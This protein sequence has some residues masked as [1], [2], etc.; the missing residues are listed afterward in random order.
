MIIDLTDIPIGISFSERD[1]NLLRSGRIQSKIL[2]M[3]DKYNFI[4]MPISIYNIIEH[5]SSFEHHHVNVTEGIFKVGSVFGYDCYVDMMILDNRIILS[6][7]VQSMRNN[8]INAILGK[9]SLL[10][11]LEIDVIL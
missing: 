4:I 1:L 11:D 5:H 6:K 10:K 7:D 3:K 2:S 8:K 9:E